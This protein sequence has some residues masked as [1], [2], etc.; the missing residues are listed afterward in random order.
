[1]S[2]NTTPSTTPPATTPAA[3]AFGTFGVTRGS[4]LARGKRSTVPAASAPIGAPQPAYKP[5]ALEVITQVSAYKNPFT[6]ETSVGAPPVNE[7]AAQ[8]ANPISPSV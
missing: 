2:Q 6:G 7:P 4:G 5:S 8:A 1:M 3:P